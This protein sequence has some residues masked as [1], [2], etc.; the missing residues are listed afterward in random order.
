[1]IKTRFTAAAGLAMLVGLTLGI[2]GPANAANSDGY[3]LCELPRYPMLTIN[4][5]QPGNGTW[6]HYDTSAPSPI[7]FPGGLS[8]QYSPYNRAWW[9]INNGPNGFWNSPPPGASCV[10]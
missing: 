4:S 5:S 7:T 3:R 10:V 2:A 9:H 6:V 1:M 8:Y